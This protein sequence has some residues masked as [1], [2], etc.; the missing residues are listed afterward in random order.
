MCVI[1]ITKKKSLSFLIHLC[2]LQGYRTGYEYK[3]PNIKV[4]KQ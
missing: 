3:L 4:S 2:L 1:Y